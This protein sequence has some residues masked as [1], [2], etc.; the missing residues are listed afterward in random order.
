MQIYLVKV[1][2]NLNIV[3]FSIIFRGSGEIFYDFS[4]VFQVSTAQTR[5]FGKNKNRKN[6]GTRK[7]DAK[8]S[9]KIYLISEV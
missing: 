2:I 9:A 5:N 7:L 6:H 1:L 4:L 3:K 8:H